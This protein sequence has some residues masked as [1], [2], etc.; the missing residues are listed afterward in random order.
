MPSCHSLCSLSASCRTRYGSCPQPDQLESQYD[1][2]F[3]SPPCGSTKLVVP[4]PLFFFTLVCLCKHPLPPVLMGVPLPPPFLFPYP[5]SVTFI[6][7]PPP[8]V[9]PSQNFSASYSLYSHSFPSI[10]LHRYYFSSRS[11]SVSMLNRSASNILD[12]NSYPTW[13]FSNLP[14]TPFR[15]VPIM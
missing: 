3:M 11:L 12:S 14:F 2:F 13:F 4:T 7:I 10:I 5:T 8:P 15:S 6:Y 9:S 1:G